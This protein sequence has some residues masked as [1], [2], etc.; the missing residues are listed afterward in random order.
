MTIVA[1]IDNLASGPGNIC[2]RELRRSATFIG[3]AV[4]GVDRRIILAQ[5]RD[6]ALPADLKAG[7]RVS[8][9]SPKLAAARIFPV[10]STRRTRHRR[11]LTLINGSI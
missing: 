2:R 11:H 1:V 6:L 8:T 4:F 7:E 3:D 9:S 5:H 10:V